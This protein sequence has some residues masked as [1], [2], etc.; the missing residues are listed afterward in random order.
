MQEEKS[1]G[2]LELDYV[3]HQRFERKFLNVEPT[4]PDAAAGTQEGQ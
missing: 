4:F 1:S 2:Y 3:H